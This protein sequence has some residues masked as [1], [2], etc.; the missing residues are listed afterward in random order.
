MKSLTSVKKII[1]NWA[2]LK[3]IVNKI[4]VSSVTSVSEDA[5]SAKN[6]QS[7]DIS[8]SG[9]QGSFFSFFVR[10]LGRSIHMNNLHAMQYNNSS[11]KCQNSNY[12]SEDIVI[13]VPTQNTANELFS[14]KRL[15]TP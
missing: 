8:V 14:E 1:E 7:T 11:N 6:V 9:S 15:P 3:Q 10:E 13:V 5:A 4:T 2:E 12:I